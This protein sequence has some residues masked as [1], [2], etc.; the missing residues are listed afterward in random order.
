MHLRWAGL[1][2]VLLGLILLF[3][4]D[5]AGVVSG[6]IVALLG[7]ATWMVTRFGHW[8]GC[9]WRRG[10]R[11]SPHPGAAVGIVFILAAALA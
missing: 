8:S 6:I 7:V 3:H 11:L 4:G 9:C 1:S 2:C 10:R 5:N